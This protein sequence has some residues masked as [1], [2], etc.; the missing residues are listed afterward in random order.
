MHR[1][2]VYGTRALCGT[3]FIGFKERAHSVEPPSYVGVRVVLLELTTTRY[4]IHCGIE[5]LDTGY[6]LL[7]LRNNLATSVGRATGRENGP[8]TRWIELSADDQ[9]K[10]LPEILLPRKTRN[11]EANNRLPFFRGPCA[12]TG[13]IAGRGTR[14]SPSCGA[15]ACSTQSRPPR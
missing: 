11:R 10:R 6:W 9:E 3:P 2:R 14:G 4:D 12:C 5:V 15:D 8:T 1:D 7:V 13:R